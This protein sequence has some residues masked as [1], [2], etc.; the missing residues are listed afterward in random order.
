MVHPIYDI[1]GAVIGGNYFCPSNHYNFE[2]SQHNAMTSPTDP[3]RIVHLAEFSPPSTTRSWVSNPAPNNIPLIATATSDKTVRV[4]SLKNFT[5]HSTLDGGHDRSIR[6]VAWKPD[7]GKNGFL[8][9]AT[10]SFDA[11]MGIWR[12]KVESAEREGN[13]DEEEEDSGLAEVEIGADAKPKP[14][15]KLRT[16]NDF[17]DEEAEE[18]DDDDDEWQFNLVLEG[19][20][21]EIKSIAYS[22]SGQYLAS[23][24]RDKSIWIWEE[25]EDEE[26]ETIAVLQDH[27]AD[28]K[29]VAWG[30]FGGEQGGNGEVLVSGS[31]DDTIRFWREDGEG[32]WSCVGVLEGHE[33]T[34]WNL[35]FEPKS[36][37]QKSIPESEREDSI[38]PIPR[39]ISCSADATIRMWTKSKPP[40]PM[41][42]PSYFNSGIPS[43][44]RPAPS[45]EIWECTNTLPSAHTLP[46]YS[47]SWSEKSGRI[48]ST[49]GDGK[50]VIYEEVT[51]GRSSVGGAIEKEWVVSGSLDGAHGPYEI[52]HVSWCSRFDG[53]RKGEE[54]MLVTT[55][56]DG[57][58]RAWAVEDSGDIAAL[59]ISSE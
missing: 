10:G 26:F 14:A 15:P 42:K 44:M 24:S 52:N 41:N 51:K 2:Y 19:H 43:T 57:V 53:G 30:S 7:S 13:L 3:L 37:L 8:C 9:L 54:E 48:A 29:C 16:Y 35:A 20:D 22:P 50:L 34:V 23:C 25:I 33:G 1:R 31:Y 5:L 32:E 56:D 12:R 28:V 59:K 55:G 17:P 45:N 49:G 18:R 6:N 46:I 40:P 27:T 47:V 39:L 38:S 4:Y 11:T 21:S 36:Y 58:V